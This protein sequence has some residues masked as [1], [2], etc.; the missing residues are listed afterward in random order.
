MIRLG[1]SL[2]FNLI[3]YT[4][5]ILATNGPDF[6]LICQSRLQDM[7]KSSSST[8]LTIGGGWCQRNASEA[9]T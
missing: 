1:Q 2:E 9:R 8:L 3:G 6:S 5:I 4:V 7:S